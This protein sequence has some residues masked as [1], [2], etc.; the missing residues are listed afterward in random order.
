MTEAELMEKKE[1]KG[2]EFCYTHL[3]T[4]AKY[5]LVRYLRHKLQKGFINRD[6]PPAENELKVRT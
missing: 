6:T 1:T 4:N 5:S 3:F 2:K